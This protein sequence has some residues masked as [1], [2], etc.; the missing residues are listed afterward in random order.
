MLAPPSL[1]LAVA[2]PLLAVV[3]RAAV[4]PPRH[5][6]SRRRPSSSPCP[7]PSSTWLLAP[8]FLLFSPLQRA[9]TKAIGRTTSSSARSWKLPPGHPPP[10]K[11]LN[12]WD[13][14]PP[15]NLRPPGCPLLRR[16]LRCLPSHM[17]FPML[18][19]CSTE[20]AKAAAAEALA[21]EDACA[22]PIPNPPTC[23]QP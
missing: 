14:S 4:P 3:A 23:S 21:A 11:M 1:L 12:L 2:V 9:R 5:G 6:C 8:P 16:Y 13:G 10:T 17:L 22:A 7:S 18:A 20:S 19:K 15:A